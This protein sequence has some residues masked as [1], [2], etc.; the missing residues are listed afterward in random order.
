VQ[1][2]DGSVKDG[3]RF[4]G[5][6]AAPRPPRAPMPRRTRRRWAI[7][8]GVAVGWLIALR[9]TGTALGATVLLVAVAGL[10]AAGVAGLRA[11]GITRDH[12]WLQRIS[13]RPWRGG[14]DVLKVAMRHLPEVFIVTPSGALIAPDV[15]ELQMNPAD[16][17]SLRDLM[18]LDVVSDSLTEVYE[19]EVAK[20]GARLTRSERPEVYVVPNGSLP[21]GRYQLQRGVPVM[22][23][24]PADQ[25]SW[26][27][28]PG[29]DPAERQ[30]TRVDQEYAVPAPAAPA[31]AGA[32]AGYGGRTRMDVP[33]GRTVMDGLATIMEQIGPVIPPLRLVT[34]AAVAETTV[35]GARA[36]RGTVELA[37]P[38]VPTVS[39][40]HAVF[41]FGAGHWWV[42]NQGSNG[43]TING[44]P[45]TG[46][47]PLSDG[48][49]IRWGKSKE[50]PLS[51]VEI[52]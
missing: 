32:G 35:S 24:P 8:G 14:Q 3:A 1:P 11:M 34:G 47:H 20:A 52:G 51:R 21:Q 28:E 25:W 27:D 10:G 5:R 48:D 17:A 9:L 7:A 44:A 50:A 46:K 30:Y 31:P 22:A 19:H 12:P 16:L 33:P 23:R 39:R 40:V 15:V 6:E 38:E 29:P 45:V 42:T 36:G 26:P 13:A 4:D 2:Y 18:G 41:T 49:T 43:L 37:L